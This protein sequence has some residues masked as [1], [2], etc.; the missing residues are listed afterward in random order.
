MPNATSNEHPKQTCTQKSTSTSIKNSL[1]HYFTAFLTEN[2]NLIENKLKTKQQTYQKRST[3]VAKH[4]N[5]F[6]VKSFL[7]KTSDRVNKIYSVKA[8]HNDA[9]QTQTKKSV[10]QKSQRNSKH[11][12][13]NDGNAWL[14]AYIYILIGL[15][16]SIFI[17]FHPIG[18]I[19]MTLQHY[20]K[21]VHFSPAS[22]Y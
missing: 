18:Y 21:M 8:T 12:H 2:L 17:L 11:M 5:E 10:F 9:D 7:G 6:N 4:F 20:H 3:N 1:N 19:I 13:G 22:N 16:D 14:H 15:I